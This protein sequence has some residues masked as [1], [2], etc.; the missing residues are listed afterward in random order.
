M[1]VWK[2]LSN[3]QAKDNK[4]EAISFFDVASCIELVYMLCFWF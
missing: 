1:Y 2:A 3:Q 4:Q